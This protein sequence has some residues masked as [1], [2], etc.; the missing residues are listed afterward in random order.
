MQVFRQRDMR[1]ELAR[2]QR[3]YGLALLRRD[4]D[5]RGAQQGLDYLREARQSFKERGA[6]LDLRMVER[7]LARYEKA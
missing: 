2:T 1:L 5:K 6:A 4:A 7:D 3:R